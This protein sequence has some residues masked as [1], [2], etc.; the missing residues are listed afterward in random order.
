MP[1]AERWD[2]LSASDW[3]TFARSWI[4]ELRGVRRESQRDVSQSVVM[5]NFTARP[6]HQWHFILAAV[7]HASDDELGDIAAGP[8]EHLLG[9]HGERYIENVEQRAEADPKFARMLAGVWKYMMTDEVWARVQV[10]KARYAAPA[11]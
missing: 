1:I 11:E 5:M 2:Q 9:K 4:A 7:G 6:E 10:L 8:M 3:D